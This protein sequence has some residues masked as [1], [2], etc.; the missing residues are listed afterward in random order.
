MLVDLV[1]TIGFGDKLSAARYILG[2][3]YEYFWGMFAIAEG[4]RGA[5]FYTQPASLKPC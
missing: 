1:S 4:K 3:V 5:Q 2:Q